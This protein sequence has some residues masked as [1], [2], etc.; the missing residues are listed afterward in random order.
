MKRNLLSIFLVFCLL[1]SLFSGLTLAASAAEEALPETLWI[2]PSASNN[3]PAKILLCTPFV[4]SGGGGGGIWG[5][6]G[7]WGGGGGAVTPTPTEEPSGYQLYLPGNVAPGACFLSWEGGL[8]ASDGEHTYLSGQLPIPA[9]GE[10][11]TYT[12]TL[13]ESTKSF[14]VVTYQGSEAVKPIFIEI[15]ESQGTIAAMNADR[16]HETTCTGIIFIDG[17]EMNLPKM[18]G[19]GNYSWQNA[20]QKRPYNITLENKV[21]ILGIAGEKTKKWSL[22]ANVNDHTLLRNKVAYDL[23]Y[24]MGIGFDSATADIW[25]NGEYQG[26]YLVTPKT[27]SFI[28]DDGY[29]I[30]NDNYREDS[31]ESG[32]D[33]SFTISGTRESTTTYAT[34]S[35]LTT[36]KKIGDNLLEGGVETPETLTAAAA[37]IRSYL[38]EAWDAVGAKDGRNSQ[39]KYYT[40][41]FDLNKTACFYLFQEFVKNLEVDG[42][43]IFFHRNG[44]AETDKLLAGPAWDYDNALGFNGTSFGGSD[45]LSCSDWFFAGTAST[46]PGGFYGT[47]GNLFTALRRH[48]DLQEAARRMYNIYHASFD[49]VGKNVA[50][51]ADE[52]EASAEMN[53]ARVTKETMNAYDFSSAKTKDAGTK[54]EVTY[55]VT[56]TWRDYIDN[57]ITY[58]SMRAQFFADELTDEQLQEGFQ[59]SFDCDPGSS[60]TVYETQ[61]ATAAGVENALSAYAR[62]SAT[63]EIDLTGEG[64]INFRVTAAENH[65]IANVIVSPSENYKNLK[66]IAPGLYRVTKMTGDILIR[67]V[68]E[69]VTCLHEFADG[70]CIHC[71]E[72]AHRIQF[73]C[74]EHCSVTVYDTQT[75]ENGTE[76]ADHA[77]AKNSETGEIDLSG[78]GQVNFVVVPDLGYAVASVTAAPAKFKNLKPPA[79][80]MSPNYYRITK[81]TGDLTVTITVEKTVCAH[82]Y[83][84]TVTPPTCTANG[85]TTYTCS[86]CGESYVAEETTRLAH[87]FVDGVCIYCHGKLFAVRFLAEH[88]T[89]TVYESQAENS[90]FTVN[91]AVAYARSSD[92]GLLDTS[93]DGQVN[94]TVLPEDGYTITSVTAA[95]GESYKNLKLPEETGAGYRVTKISGD[96]TITVT[97]EKSTCEHLYAAV[98]TAPSCTA[99]GYTTYTC[100]KCGSSY[101]DNE[102]AAL[103]HDLKETRVEATCTAPGSVT[104]ACSRCDAQE[105]TELP[106]L[107]HDWKETRVEATCTAA[108]SVT[109]ACSRCDQQEVTVLPA[110][111]HN[112]KETRVE[113]TCTAAG[114]V[115]K[116]CSRCD[117]Q[118]VTVLPALGHTLKETK[119]EAT[120]T[121]AGSVTKACSRCDYQEVTEAA[122]LG[123]AYKAAVT[124][125]TCTAGGSTTFTCTRCGDSYKGNETAALGHDL[126]ETRVDATCTA[127][128]SVTTTC[129]RCDKQEITELPALGHDYV[130]GKCSRC[131]EA[132]TAYECSGGD[133]CPAKTFTDAPKPGTWAHA[134]IDYCVESGLMNGISDELF[135]PNGTVTR[136]QLVT[137]LYR[138]A[139]APAFTTEKSFTDVKGGKYYTEAVLWAAENEIVNGYA[140]GTFKPDAA[141]SREQIAAILY[142]YAGSPGIDGALDFPDSDKASNYARTALLWA[143]QKELITGLKTADGTLLSPKTNATRAQIATIIMRCQR[144]EKVFSPR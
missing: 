86:K 85:Y 81:I 33:P 4:A 79:E 133:T 1:I 75:L 12:F 60:V 38:Q 87:E 142:R 44:T 123:H 117:Q 52:I 84:P 41:Y 89:V 31:V 93:G 56:D 122:A 116:T 5:G 55:K 105:V 73:D 3:I 119:V 57:L 40:D 67:V 124:A 115:T 28:T 111:G 8:S 82:T 9:P 103:G 128:G 25:M 24:E 36:V 126:K 27:D 50:A 26:T 104:K 32:G 65:R 80:T 72:K 91:P 143:T 6:W 113:A 61:D 125:P 35:L 137:I 20:V 43:S 69:S 108:G 23:A 66:E 22:L 83:A 14:E 42:G 70:Q 120:C 34:N 97:T 140:D 112:V 94:F 49:R 7:G 99:K 135:K 78:D 136:A 102:T 76:A 13:G 37:G 139:G 71:G 110:L 101:L 47:G 138:I 114:S 11:K 77:F 54:Y 62:N 15:D 30:E 96:L 95:P 144:V 10:T 98:V 17:E 118:E 21:N 46:S 130:N 88:A 53:F 45:R 90:P 134:G 106:A 131:G 29:L 39:G 121:A 92:T 100:A 16:N 141:I 18:K 132:D 51:F 63:G 109:K 127:A 19:R 59:A 2:A 107:G 74:G 58:T 68:T 129:S 48:E 64:Q